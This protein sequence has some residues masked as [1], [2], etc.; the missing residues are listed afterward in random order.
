MILPIG[1]ESQEVRRLPWV[2]FAVIALC[3]I[4][5]LLV[6]PAVKVN[7]SASEEAAIQAV[8]YWVEHPYLEL[9]PEFKAQI[10]LNE[11]EWNDLRQSGKGAN[12]SQ[13]PAQLQAEQEWLDHLTGIFLRTLHKNPYYRWGLIPKRIGFPGLISHM[14]IHGGWLHLLGNM[15][16]FFLTG[17]F[18]EDIWGRWLYGFFY[19]SMGMLA[20]LI[21]CLHYPNQNIILIGA[22]GAIAGVMGAF[23]VYFWKTRIR[24]AFFLTFLFSGTFKAPAWMMLPLWVGVESL[25]AHTMDRISPGL[26]DG[27]VAHWAHVWGFALGFLAAMVLRWTGLV[28]RRIAPA[29]EK[30]T[31]LSDPGLETYEQGLIRLE[32]KD[33]EAARDSFLA[34]ARSHPG[35]LDILEYLEVATRHTGERD[36]FLR[37]AARVIEH[38]LHKKDTATALALYHRLRQDTP[39]ESIPI[40]A[41]ALLVQPLLDSGNETE[42]R[43]L[44]DHVLLNFAPDLPHGFFFAL[45][46]PARRLGGE[47]I[48]RLRDLAQ[49]RPDLP[50]PVQQELDKNPAGD[51][52]EKS[53]NCRRRRELRVTTAVPLR[54]GA[55]LLELR[56]DN[57]AERRLELKRVASLAVVALATADG[58]P[59]L[60]FDLFLDDPA[61]D[62]GPLRLLRLDSKAF[63]PRPLAAPHSGTAE[64]F[65]AFVD[66]LLE[67]SSARPW[68]DARILDTRRIP[69]YPD[70]DAYHRELAGS[71]G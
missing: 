69:Q 13:D 11:S 36:L 18:I 42:A 30:K 53:A 27:G 56:L 55:D 68:P 47:R 45:A 14:F 33:Y 43:T 46:E 7:R 38:R 4:T 25:N 26:R 58:P 48:E 8:W 61:A 12:P 32:K 54:L 63:D 34:A 19:L 67:N 64:A 60:L 70:L 51:D 6:S 9:D 10:S 20:G 17:P 57:G 21:Y 23:L 50:A 39:A 31:R 62:E 40:R 49:N 65:S 16:F 41:S 28:Q 52:G 1:H 2:S 22:S 29:I 24:F 59:N 44:M 3:V 15:L 66:R 35:D 37:Q 71:T 5:H